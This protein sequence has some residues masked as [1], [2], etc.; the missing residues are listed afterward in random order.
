MTSFR[1]KLATRMPQLGLLMMYPS[2]GALERIGQDWD[3]I[4]IDAQHGQLGY[5]DTVAM[6]RACN[7]IDRPAF[8]RVPWLEPGHIGLVLDM[9][10]DGVI[11]PCVDTPEMARAAVRVAKFPP[12]GG[13]SYGGRRAIDRQ[14]RN[15]SN[16]AN[17]D[18]LLVVQIES[19]EAIDN[20]DAIAATDG[21]DALFLGTDDIIL[22]R[23]VSP[24][25]GY[26]GQRF[27]CCFQRVQKT[28]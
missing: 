18:V 4:W 3:W 17:Q 26:A 6:V 25:P 11:V 14:G 27:V 1:E 24:Q 23:G 7:L 15:Y 8:V 28:R 12:V 9:G 5:Q 16:T 19:P 20:V 13:R 2:P 21:V 10:A 22:H